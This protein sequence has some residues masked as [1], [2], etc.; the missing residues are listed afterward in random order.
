MPHL[1]NPVQLLTRKPIKKFN[2]FRQKKS[3]YR[4]PPETQKTKTAL[5]NQ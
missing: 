3:V 4:H 2:I 1:K 5:K